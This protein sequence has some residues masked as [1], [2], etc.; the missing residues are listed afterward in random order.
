MSF[1]ERLLSK[2]GNM[3][4]AGSP[5]RDVLPAGVSTKDAQGPSVAREASQTGGPHSPAHPAR[6]RVVQLGLNER[7]V[8]PYLLLMMAAQTVEVPGKGRVTLGDL[9]TGDAVM[10]YIKAATAEY[11]CDYMQALHRSCVRNAFSR[12][13]RFRKD[14]EAG[15][16]TMGMGR[17]CK[18]QPISGPTT[19]FVSHCWAYK[20][21]DLVTLVMRH[22]DSQPGTR[23]G[24]EY[25]PLYYWVDIFAV[26]QNFSGDFKDHP[27]S[28]FPGVIRGSEGVL[29]TIMPW[30]APLNVERVWCVYEALQAVSAHVPLD[31]LVEDVQSGQSLDK[32]NQVF[33]TVVVDKLDI[34]RCKAT[35]A[36]DKQYIMGEIEKMLSIDRFNQ[37]M[38]DALRKQVNSVMLR[39]AVEQDNA[40]ATTK[41]I[42]SGVVVTQRVLSFTGAQTFCG[43]DK[44]LKALADTL[45]VSLAVSTVLVSTAPTAKT[46]PEGWALLAGALKSNRTVLDLTV[47]RG[48]TEELDTHAGGNIGVKFAAALGEALTGNSTLRRLELSRQINLG[49]KGVIALAKELGRIESSGLTE[50]VLRE[51]GADGKSVAQLADAIAIAA[52]ATSNGPA[53]PKRFGGSGGGFGLTGS[54]LEGRGG[55]DSPHNRSFSSG[56]SPLQQRLM[57]MSNDVGSPVN[58]FSVARSANA[59]NNDLSSRGMS[60]SAHGGSSSLQPSATRLSVKLPIARLELSS[61]AFGD[62]EGPVALAKLLKRSP[63]LATLDL[64][65]C[66]LGPAGA[67]ALAAGV[68]GSAALRHLDLGN[69]RIGDDGAA[70]LADALKSSPRLQV[71]LLPRCGIGATGA[72]ALGSA[73]PAPG[74]APLCELDLSQNPIGNAGAVAIG[75]GLRTQGRMSSLRRVSLQRVGLGNE[76]LQSV[77]SGLGVNRSLQELDLEGNRLSGGAAVEKLLMSAMQGNTTLLRL[78]LTDCLEL[79]ALNAIVEAIFGVAP[80][81][82]LVK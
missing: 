49:S 66:A 22:Y 81:L 62:G 76:G 75:Q 50:L 40:D 7:A 45:K 65:C 36:K 74:A 52:A 8:H 13:G 21:R 12:G 79:G 70:A 57:K 19:Y 20:F 78:T 54:L 25:Q 39:Q 80:Q 10:G 61:N 32:L 33:Q 34:R 5:A 55:G 1:S 17:L 53:S 46:T 14:M 67:K 24:H 28:D 16:A 30:R 27:D 59:S 60:F 63:V 18:D 43:S 2:L 4:R 68:A 44:G 71:L 51:V 26:N 72:S 77:L 58:S 23:G 41:L 15:P 9:T 73:L 47:T 38:Q 6:G 42:R 56:T 3:G 82:E 48:P 29:F 31:L 11:G 69:N 37:I 35:V 64:R